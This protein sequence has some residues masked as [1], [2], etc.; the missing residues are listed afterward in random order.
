M[1]STERLAV[2]PIREEHFDDLYAVYL[3]NPDYL[4]M[5]E[6]TDD[7]VGVYTKEQMLRD[8]QVAEWTG[9]TPLG[10]FLRAERK[11]IGVLEYWEQADTDGKPWVGLLMIH[12]DHQRKGYGAEVAKAFLRFA[13]ECG[14]PEVRLG[15]LKDNESALAFW[16]S[17]GFEP[18]DIREKRLP[19]GL[20]KVIC[21]RVSFGR[22]GVKQD[23]PETE[24]GRWE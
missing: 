16:S 8:L 13:E 23:R 9:R 22:G 21:M 3:S 12:R 18:F 2:S 5:T 7:G 19:A 11:L 14:W 4:R 20:K 6:G 10:V 15:V 1:F 17:L 24:N